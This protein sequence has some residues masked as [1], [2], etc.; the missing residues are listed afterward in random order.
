TPPPSRPPLRPRRS[1][2]RACRPPP[3]ERRWP[4]P[5]R[6]RLPSPAQPVRPCAHSVMAPPCPD[7]PLLLRATHSH[8]ASHSRQHSYHGHGAT[9]LSERLELHRPMLRAVGGAIHS[10]RHQRGLSQAAVASHCRFDRA[11]L[12]T[13]EAGL[14]NPT[15]IT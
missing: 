3:G 9:A 15:L 13:I 2:P 10:R 7:G 8:I 1:R 12:S 6:T 11:Y 4:R 5:A 14:R